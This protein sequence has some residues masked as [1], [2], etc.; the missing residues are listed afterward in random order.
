MGD[1]LLGL[2]SDLSTLVLFYRTDIFRSLGLSPARTWSELNKVIGSLEAKG[3]RYY[4][5]FTLKTQWSTKLYTMPYGLP[6]HQLRP[7]GLPISNWDNP[8]FQQGVLEALRLWNMHDSPGKDLESR[9]VGMFRS[10]E[11][12]VAIPLMLDLPGMAGRIEPSAPEMAG[13]WDV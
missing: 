1:K 6:E 9:V 3:Y 4:F 2:P 8:K 12:G 5:G 11:P 7:D 13:K 10:D